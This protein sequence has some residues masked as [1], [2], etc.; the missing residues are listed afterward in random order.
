MLRMIFF[1]DSNLGYM[2]IWDEI[3]SQ[4][5]EITFTVYLNVITAL[6]ISSHFGTS[7]WQSE[8][9]HG[10]KWGGRGSQIADLTGVLGDAL[11]KSQ[12]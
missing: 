8:R 11:I 10:G 9:L 2:E 7:A 1:K 3:S 12:L 4:G 6:T 5:L